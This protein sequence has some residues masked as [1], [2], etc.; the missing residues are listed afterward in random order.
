MRSLP[1]FIG[2]A[3]GLEAA[4]FAPAAIGP[5]NILRKIWGGP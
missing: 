4:I 3:A 5:I 2:R 1:G